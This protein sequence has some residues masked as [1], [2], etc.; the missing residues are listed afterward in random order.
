MTLWSQLIDVARRMVREPQKAADDLV[1]AEPAARRSGDGI[2][3]RNGDFSV[4]V[5][6]PMLAVAATVFEGDPLPP[7]VRAI[8]STLGGFCLGLA[9]VEDG[10][11]LGGL[12][13]FDQI[14]AI[15]VLLE[16]DLCCGIT[17]LLV[18]MALMPGGGGAGRAWAS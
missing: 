7:L 15:F 6:E 5:T 3:R 1:A 8:G 16:G 12:G 2:H 13:G 9:F 18:F 4:I 17:V 11:F 10:G 14:F